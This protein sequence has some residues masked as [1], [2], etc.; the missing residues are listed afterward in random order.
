MSPQSPR[1]NGIP[2]C[3]NKKLLTDILRKELGFKGYVISD[4]G[5]VENIIERHHF[6]KTKVDT[7]A[8]CV[9][10][11]CNLELS[12][13]LTDAVFMHLGGSVGVSVC[14]DSCDGI[15]P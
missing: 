6:L 8:A 10:A 11:G 3:A 15:D 1:I 5:A 12:S 4:E 13:N 7:V 2:A 9:N 14:V